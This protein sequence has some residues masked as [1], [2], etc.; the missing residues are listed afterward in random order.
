MRKLIV[1]SSDLY[2]RNFIDTGAFSAIED[3]DTYY[4]ASEHVKHVS[5][6]RSKKNFLGLVKEPGWRLFLN[7][8]LLLLLTFLNKSKSSSFR[9]RIR[10]FH[11]FILLVYNVLG[12]RFFGKPALWVLMKALGTNRE[13]SRIVKELKPDIVLIPSSATDSLGTDATIVCKKIGIPCVHLINGWD[14]LSSKIVYPVN[15]DYLCVWGP[16]SVE[17]A[18]RIHGIRPEKVF[19]IG[20][21]TFDHYFRLRDRELESPHPFKYALFAGCCVAFDEISALQILE[22]AIERSGIKGFKVVYRPHPWR[23]RRSCFDEFR[24]E[25]FKHVILDEQIKESYL[26]S[27]AYVSPADFLPS[28]DYYPALLKNAEF[29]ICPLSTMTLESA[30]FEK[31]TLIIAYDDGI[32][33]TSPHNLF[34]YEHFRG[35]EKLDGM[36]LCKTKEAF[37]TLFLSMCKDYVGSNP[38]KTRIR[39]QIKYYIYYDDSSYAERLKKVVDSLPISRP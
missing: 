20:V 23:H 36:S 13:L 9:L 1:V 8:Q 22:R 4:L 29:V 37:E 34:N 12:S 35:I 3:E 17:H 5:E 26:R 18:E 30:I 39:E 10:R 21:P 33:V 19:P 15:P 31:P 25:N 16:Q 11:P 7:N 32:H 27:N 6:L 28:L 24:Q 38:P 2:V 14:N